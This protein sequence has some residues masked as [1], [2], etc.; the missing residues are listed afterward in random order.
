MVKPVKA[1]AAILCI[2][3]YLP[4]SVTG[5]TLSKDGLDG[6]WIYQRIVAEDY[7]VDVNR[8]IEFKPDGTVVTYHTPDKELSTA[9]YEVKGNKVIY[10][11]EKGAQ[12]WVVLNYDG[13]ALVVDHQ[14]AKMFFERP[15]H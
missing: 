14:G 12:H 11:D 8:F 7:S 6:K 2:A 1:C 4:V 9:T 5:E 13:N 3:M 15:A 10:S